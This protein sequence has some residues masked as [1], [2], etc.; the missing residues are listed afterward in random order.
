MQ[1]LDHVAIRVSDLDAAMAFYV[2]KLG[3][4]VLF[5]KL[6][7]KHHETFCFL[8]MEGANLELLQSLDDKNRPRPF[9]PPPVR[10]PYC[11]HLAIA[12]K[13]LDSLLAQWKKDGIPV[14][15]GPLEIPDTVRWVYIH[16]PDNN[17]IEFV[18][19]L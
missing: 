1:K 19:W 8:Q 2:D 11:P 16:D 12:T 13:D 5:R 7:E 9:S 3:M 15:K 17:V 4:N 10:E 6:D 18:H 14:V